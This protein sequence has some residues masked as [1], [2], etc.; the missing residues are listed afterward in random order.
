MSN[1][2]MQTGGRM[3]GTR[4]NTDVERDQRPSAPEI[5][6]GRHAPYVLLLGFLLYGTQI[7]IEILGE[8]WELYDMLPIVAVAINVLLVAAIGGVAARVFGQVMR[9]ASL[10]T[11]LRNILGEPSWW[12]TW[13]PRG[14]R[15]PTSVWDR[16][17]LGLKLIRSAL[18]VGSLVVPAGLVL[19]VFVI[20]TF[21]VV[22]ESMG[23]RFPLMIRTYAS[24]VTVS[25][26]VFP[27]VLS[28]TLVQVQRWS[29]RHGLSTMAGI[30]A[31]F[32]GDGEFWRGKD[33]RKLLTG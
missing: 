2:T 1:G 12:R 13:Y 5:W 7:A 6:V 11:I 31:L 9:R 30:K 20:P 17:P 8:W 3:S 33:G 25:A 4:Q 21:R 16:L 15:S 27:V 24:V 26:Y 19:A 10:P 18:W 14:L 29:V 28:A 32:A 23:V 22:Y